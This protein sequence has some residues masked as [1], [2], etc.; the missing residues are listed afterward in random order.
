MIRR[1]RESLG[2]SQARLGELVGRSAST[3]RNWERGKS[4]P[5]APSDAVALAAVLG[6]DEQQVVEAAGFEAGDIRAHQTVEQGYASLAPERPPVEGAS[7][8]DDTSGD[9]QVSRAEDPVADDQ[10]EAEEAGLVATAD[11]VDPPVRWERVARRPVPEHSASPLKAVEAE[12]RPETD[13]RDLA[14]A[15]PPT[16]LEVAPPHEPSYVEDPTERQRYRTR[17]V[18]TAVV[19]LFLVVVFLWSF[20]RAVDALGTMWQDFIGMLEL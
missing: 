11:P 10:P 1:R 19:V 16:V 6:L 9:A 12:V 14:R 13:Q 17:A 5:A 2:F 18:A 8:R 4:T 15:A 3:I 7:D 20:D